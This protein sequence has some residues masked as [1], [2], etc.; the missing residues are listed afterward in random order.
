[1]WRAICLGIVKIQAGRAVR[2]DIQGD[3][4]LASDVGETKSHRAIGGNPH[5]TPYLAVTASQHELLGFQA[6]GLPRSGLRHHEQC[7][8]HQE[9]RTRKRSQLS[10][11][12]LKFS[13]SALQEFKALDQ[14]S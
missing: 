5:R 7:T 12:T 14:L 6:L 13:L 2:L 10:V 11:G 8:S 3:S 9:Q 4:G 1:M